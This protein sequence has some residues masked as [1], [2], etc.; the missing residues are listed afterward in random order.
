M[1]KLI[2]FPVYFITKIMA[3]HFLDWKRYDR[4]LDEW[5]EVALPLA[6]MFGIAYWLF[7]ITIVLA[8]F[9]LMWLLLHPCGGN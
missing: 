8:V 5:T 2:L 6:Y 1:K 7:G 9:R 3:R 4:S